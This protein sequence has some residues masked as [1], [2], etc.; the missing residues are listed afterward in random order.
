MALA[1]Q[2]KA[3]YWFMLIDPARKTPTTTTPT[4]A[5]WLREILAS[6]DECEPPPSGQAGV[7]YL[8][9]LSEA[10]MLKD[11]LFA[12]CQASLVDYPK[13]SIECA[14][15]LPLVPRPLDSRSELPRR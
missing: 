11:L 14:E 13:S 4:D 7:H 1:K 12:R 15:P 3:R 10:D 9:G 6:I 2:R 8:V 5:E